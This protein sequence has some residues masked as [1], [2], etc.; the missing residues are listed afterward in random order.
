M[1]P[2]M[3]SGSA[4]SRVESRHRAKMRR[5]RHGPQSTALRLCNVMENF[6][7]APSRQSTSREENDG[8]RMHANGQ[9]EQAIQTGQPRLSAS[10]GGMYAMAN[11]KGNG[12]AR[13]VPPPSASM[14][15]PLTRTD[16]SIPLSSITMPRSSPRM[17]SEVKNRVVAELAK[18][19]SVVMNQKLRERQELEE[20]KNREMQQVSDLPAPVRRPRSLLEGTKGEQEAAGLTVGS[21]SAAFPSSTHLSSSIRTFHRKLSPEEIKK[22]EAA[23]QALPLDQLMKEA[24]PG[25]IEGASGEEVRGSS[26]VP[27]PSPA[28]HPATRATS[29]NVMSSNVM[30]D[31][32]RSGGEV[33]GSAA[34]LQGVLRGGPLPF[35]LDVR[36]APLETLAG[37][38][39]PQGLPPHSGAPQDPSSLLSL[40][41][42][43]KNLAALALPGVGGAEHCGRRERNAIVFLD[44]KQQALA[45]PHTLFGG[46]SQGGAV[47]PREDVGGRY[48]YDREDLLSHVLYAD[49][50]KEGR[51]GS[52]KGSSSEETVPT[53]VVPA[54]S[55]MVVHTIQL[56]EEEE[57]AAAEAAAERAAPPP[58]TK[59]II[60][61]MLRDE[62]RELEEREKQSIGLIRVQRLKPNPH[63]NRGL[64]AW[65]TVYHGRSGHWFGYTISKL[66]IRERVA[67]ARRRMIVD[68]PIK[69]WLGS[70]FTQSGSRKEPSITRARD[71]SRS[72]GEDERERE[73]REDVEEWVRLLPRDGHLEEHVEEG[74]EGEGGSP[75]GPGMDLLKV[76]GISSVDG[77]KDARRRV[78]TAGLGAAMLAS[79][80]EEVGG[81]RVHLRSSSFKEE[82]NDDA[83]S[84]LLDPQRASS[85]PAAG[86]KSAPFSVFR[87]SRPD[88][89]DF[90]K[91]ASTEWV[92]E[93]VNFEDRAAQ[94]R[95]KSRFQL[96]NF[97]RGGYQNGETLRELITTL[98]E[99][100]DEKYGKDLTPEEREE[101]KKRLAQARERMRRD[102][103]LLDA[104]TRGGSGK[105]V[106]AWRRSPATTKRGLS[107]VDADSEAVGMASKE[108]AR[109]SLSFSKGTLEKKR[110]KTTRTKKGSGSPSS[111]AGVPASDT[112]RGRSPILLSPSA[113][114]SHAMR[115]EGRPSTSGSPSLASPF[116]SRPRTRSQRV[117][118]LL[119]PTTSSEDHKKEGGHRRPRTS[120]HSFPG[121]NTEDDEASEGEQGK[122]GRRTKTGR[123][124]AHR[125]PHHLTSPMEKSGSSILLRS[126]PSL[127]SGSMIGFRLHR[128]G[129]NHHNR[130]GRESSLSFLQKEE[131]GS[132]QLSF[133]DSF[134]RHSDILASDD[135]KKRRKNEKPGSLWRSA[136]GRAL[137]KGEEEDVDL[138]LARFPEAKKPIGARRGAN[139]I[140]N[141]FDQLGISSLSFTPSASR[142]N[143]GSPNFSFS[144]GRGRSAQGDA[145]ELSSFRSENAFYSPVVG[146]TV[147]EDV[148]AGRFKQEA[149]M[150]NS[151][152]MKELQAL[153]KQVEKRRKA[154]SNFQHDIEYLSF[155][156]EEMTADEYAAEMLHDV[157]EAARHFQLDLHELTME[158]EVE[159]LGSPDLAKDHMDIANV[160]M[161]SLSGSPESKIPQC[162][163]SSLFS[164]TTPLPRSRMKRNPETGEVDNAAGWEDCETR[165][166]SGE[167]R[168]GKERGRLARVYHG[169]LDHFRDGR[170][171]K[172]K[173]SVACQVT[174]E[175]LGLVDETLKLATE[176]LQDL[177]YHERALMDAIRLAT[178]AVANVMSFHASLE[179]ESTCKQ[180]F[181]LLDQPRT[182]WPC[183]HTFC[184]Q[185]LVHMCNEDDEIICSECGS[186][187]EV[188]Y[189]PNY[190]IEMIAHY[191]VVQEAVEDIKM[192]TKKTTIEGVLR[193]LLND[194][195]ATQKKVPNALASTSPNDSVRTLT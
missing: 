159:G 73:H 30:G 14:Y 138:L 8:N 163:P 32:K 21:P 192:R 24:F 195:L 91:K 153:R 136:M 184:Q 79:E 17:T 152:F 6:P 45:P 37:A 60:A 95:K 36:S 49:A 143:L 116:L 122:G 140:L 71:G 65:L 3:S 5:G 80:V 4:S 132:R 102:A 74:R 124:P 141:H 187:C 100:L 55:T 10:N 177:L 85:A 57:V 97:S 166:P 154:L 83:I 101:A 72:V 151:A 19:L 92:D 67:T 158:E 40:A 54:T 48:G 64:F 1:Q 31:A 130:G 68:G 112:E 165:P 147:D 182:L 84:S 176:Q 35:P 110:K 164:P 128:K 157:N 15:P 12:Y 183:G 16:T 43:S 119:S 53:A 47:S 175:D 162:S 155:G 63:F 181:F 82:Q 61:Q 169:F 160:S 41:A 193:N 76:V 180:C 127:L 66:G 189:T 78:D 42:L 109:P 126:S 27:A 86:H 190:A 33:D 149:E 133:S 134:Q 146:F 145:S 25:W 117:A 87:L 144:G 131:M 96:S 114:D 99:I 191:Q 28:S 23:L 111:T 185:C 20:A 77:W 179:M 135:N 94:N 173:R 170:G 186:I 93:D 89:T 62:K 52:K 174:E 7:L 172:E 139:A 34:S 38:V 98:S 156:N 69:Q 44:P 22:K 70:F 188:G 125:S 29:G 194:L 113:V 13:P 120:P 9:N 108:A 26:S 106:A 11:D 104:H 148:L 51:E 105:G 2:R 129:G 121:L 59:E 103:A 171:R 137:R 150:E 167:D 18:K 168:K 107:A 161:F 56:R 75:R 58:S 88:P 46:P 90:S 81:K 142:S 178:I 39:L 118:E 50:E 115:K 123:S